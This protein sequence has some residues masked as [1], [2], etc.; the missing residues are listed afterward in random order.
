MAGG[1]IVKVYTRPKPKRKKPISKSSINQIVK[2]QIGKH[3]E[4][5]I[6][7]FAYE[8]IGVYNTIANTNF[9]SLMPILSQGTGEGERIGNQITIKKVMLRFTIY[10]D[11]TY[12]NA[13]VPKYVDFY[14]VKYRNSNS[15]P[16]VTDANKLLQQ[17]NGATSYNGE[18]LDGLRDVNTDLYILKK[19]KRWTMC[20][21]FTATNPIG[22]GSLKGMMTMKFNITK[23]YKKYIK[24][25]DTITSP[26]N[27]NLFLCV[28]TT[29]YYQTGTPATAQTGQ[30][31]F[32]MTFTYED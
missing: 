11:S 28:G 30:M 6:Q 1:K 18:I 25:S 13:S 5:K 31:S 21:A 19:R 16:S 10:M 8:N 27:D 17:G 12:A 7:E 15:Q 20:N 3:F 14:I 4:N 24:F 22:Y 9:L 2:R 32:D 23:F 29:D 26:S